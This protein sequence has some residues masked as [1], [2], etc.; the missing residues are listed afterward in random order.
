MLNFFL[1]SKSVYISIC[2]GYKVSRTYCQVSLSQILINASHFLL[3]TNICGL[4]S[5]QVLNEAALGI[6]CNRENNH[7]SFHTVRMIPES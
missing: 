1:L 5:S 2:G 3:D 7:F 6:N 4:N